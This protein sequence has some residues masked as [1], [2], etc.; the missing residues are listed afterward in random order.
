MANHNAT[1]MAEDDLIEAYRGIDTSLISDNLGRLPGAVGIL[2]YS[3]A[4]RMIGW[5]LTVKTCSGDNKIIHEALRKTV[6]GQ[7]LVIDGGGDLS[8]ALI[9]EIIHA[10]AELRGAAG[11]VIDG[12]IRDVAAIRQSGLPCFARGVIHRGPYKNGPG[13]IGT[14]VSI[15]GMTVHTG[16]LVIG[17]DDGVVAVDPAVAA[18]I[19]PAIRAQAEH[20][21]E[22]LALLRSGHFPS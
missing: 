12:A 17:D 10:H 16:D 1:K 9:G 20:E 21:A 14:P 15:G 19:L 4:T 6:P 3:R 22:K 18:E 5:A 13:S 2:P 8:R 7:V 11:M